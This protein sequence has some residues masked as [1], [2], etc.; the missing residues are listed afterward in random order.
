MAIPIVGE[1]DAKHVRL[2]IVVSRFNRPVTD[3][4]LEGA[5]EAI[6]ECGG[7]TANVPVAHVPGAL[8]L[9]VVAKRFA[10]S[11]K[12][13]A[14]IC[15]GCVIRGKTGHYETVVAGTTRSLTQIAIDTGVPVI[16]GVLTVETPEQAHER[17]DAARKCHAG[18]DAAR[19]AIEMANLLKKIDHHR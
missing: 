16:F 13:D 15:L 9:G 17:T 14:V 3:R 12:V 5:L 19:A 18:A 8:E 11:R 2:A 7:D 6:T 10:S 4:L 1:H